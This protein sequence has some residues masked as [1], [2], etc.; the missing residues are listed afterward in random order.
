MTK[1]V[2]RYQDKHDF[3]DAKGVR[4]SGADRPSSAETLPSLGSS[5]WE[6][7][8]PILEWDLQ[9]SRSFFN[10]CQRSKLRKILAEVWFCS[11][12]VYTYCVACVV[13]GLC[14]RMH[15]LLPNN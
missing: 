11:L 7:K 1:E 5:F 3:P 9:V 13:V 2:E 12:E 10:W 4:A 8:H 6:S 14:I 15:L